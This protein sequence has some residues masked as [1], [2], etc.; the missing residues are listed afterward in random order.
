MR[1]LHTAGKNN[2][3]GDVIV[4]LL[5]EDAVR[6][7]QNWLIRIRSV[8]TSAYKPFTVGVVHFTVRRN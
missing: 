4:R 1:F 2:P 6:Q 7:R 3:N 8:R 5:Q